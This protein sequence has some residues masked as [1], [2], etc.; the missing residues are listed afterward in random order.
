MRAMASS[1]AWFLCMPLAAQEPAQPQVVATLRSAAAF[2][3]RAPKT[4]VEATIERLLPSVVKVMGASGFSTIVPYAAGVI[5]SDRGHILT[6]DQVLVQKGSTRVVLYDGTVLDA[7]LL[8]EDPKLGV[9]LLRVDPEACKGKLAPV[10][11]D[12]QQE[13]ARAGRFVVSIGNCFRLAEFSEKSSATFGVVVGRASTSLRFRLTDVAYDGELLLTD[14]ANNPG[15]YGGGLFDLQG[16][17]LGLNARLL[18]SKE[19]NTM[20][21]AA[22]PA[23]DLLPYLNEH[24]NGIAR[25][26]AEVERKPVRTGIVLFRQAGRQS[27]P[28]YV[29]RVEK[30]SPAAA[31]ALRP[32]DLI[33]RIGEFPSRN[34]KEFDDT[35]LKFAPGQKA[36]LTWKRGEKVMQGE[37]ELAEDKQ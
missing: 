10:W 20:L 37:I 17:W 31:L 33:V 5:V 34:C 16:R 18:E 7:Q 4:Q 28:A 30:G 2:S 25:V 8:P 9:R 21:S 29:D 26:E 15:H 3:E 36:L 23:R 13:H 35:L 11:P 22:I 27:P 32:D 6:L 19:T 24:V 1:I 14:A 12:E